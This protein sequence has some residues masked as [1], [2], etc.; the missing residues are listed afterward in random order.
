M[1]N[2]D[3]P[4]LIFQCQCSYAKGRALYSVVVRAV[5]EATRYR[6]VYLRA[7]LSWNVRMGLKVVFGSKYSIV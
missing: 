1:V 4:I 2:D 7:T 3:T 6:N 5:K